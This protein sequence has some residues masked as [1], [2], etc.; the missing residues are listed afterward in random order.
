MPETVASTIPESFKSIA[1]VLPQLVWI[2]ESDGRVIYYNDRIAE[3]SGASRDE[4]GSWHWE[5]LLHPEDIAATSQ[6]WSNAI[7]TG[8][9]YEIEHR[10]LRADGQYRWYLSRAFPQKNEEGHVV[11]WLGTAT[12]IDQQ[13]KTEELLKI[14]ESGL[15][16]MFDVST[17]G[18]AQADPQGYLLRVNE[19]LCRMTGYTR[20]ELMGARFS[21]FTYPEDRDLDF[22]RFRAMATGEVPEYIS[23]KR[24]VRK[25]G[26]ILWVMVTANAI[27]DSTG[28]MKHSVAVIQDITLRKTAEQDA[29]RMATHLRM[30]TDSAQVGTWFFEVATGKLEW[31]SLHKRMWGYSE[32]RTNLV[33][34]DWHS[35]IHPD[36]KDRVFRTMDQAREVSGLYDAEYRI[37]RANDGIELWM[38]SIGQFHRDHLERTVSLTGVTLD[39]TNR[40]HSDNLIKQ[41][42][43]QLRLLSESIPQLVWMSD[44]SGKCEYTTGRWLEYSGLDPKNE[45]TW[46]NMIHPDDQARLSPV[47][48]DAMSNGVPYQAEVRLKNRKGEY[49]WHSMRGEPVRD[50]DGRISKWIGVCT[51]IDEQKNSAVRLEQLVAKRTQEL[52]RSNEDLQQFAHVASHDL[53]E[54]LRKI[55][56]F[57]S[58]LYMEL[59]SHLP[60]KGLE[61]LSKIEAAVNRMSSMIDGVLQY[62]S[63]DALQQ[64]VETVDLTQ[65]VRAIESDLEVAIDQKRARIYYKDLH[66]VPGIPVLLYQLFYNLINNSLKFSR[67]EVDPEIIVSSE[68]VQEAS[69]PVLR[70]TVKDN[71]IGFEQEYAERIFNSFLRLNSKDQ[72]EGTGLGL[73]LCKKIAERH[74][75]SIEAKGQ[76]G[77]GSIFTLTLPR[78]QQ[79][80][81]N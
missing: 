60:N 7:S 18:M 73:A 4:E 5:G 6:A 14:S 45:G 58:R 34:S 74:N 28:R 39:I 65:L 81:I 3:F 36:D 31:S 77:E 25:D 76:P 41:S 2:A 20:E 53:K 56:I 38:R 33:F 69:G 15:R 70:I 29:L 26:K 24:Y 1:N 66:E 37:R 8:Q 75:G 32:D 67:K 9:G 12:D 43:E 47:F 30:A 55:K 61:Y 64:A 79:N 22:A 57:S 68:E 40:K 48:M 49:R 51:D 35:L 78:N 59:G 63:V 23:E 11:R 10:V 50:R 19:S 16:A 46:A 44:P 27:F 71:G 72:Y 62:S 13:K 54:P 80:D 52:R 17:V 42:E 21:S